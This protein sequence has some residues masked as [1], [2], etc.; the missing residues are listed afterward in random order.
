GRQKP[1]IASIDVPE[2]LKCLDGRDRLLV[3]V[4]GGTPLALIFHPLAE[5]IFAAKAIGPYNWGVSR[6]IP[7]AIPVLRAPPPKGENWLYELKLDGFRVQLHKADKSAAIYGN[8]AERTIMRSALPPDLRR[9]LLS[10]A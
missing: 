3:D 4:H 6:L 9:S 7:P 10:R 5:E 8:Y 2:L 1:F